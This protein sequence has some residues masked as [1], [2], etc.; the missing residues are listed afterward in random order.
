MKNRVKVT[1]A[2]LTIGVLAMCGNMTGYATESADAVSTQANE[3]G[4]TDAGGSKSYAYVVTYDLNEGI[5]GKYEGTYVGKYK[6]E[7]PTVE[8]S[9]ITPERAG[10]RLTG[11]WYTDTNNIE[12]EISTTEKIDLD[13]W[14]KDTREATLTAEW[15]QVVTVTVDGTETGTKVAADERISVNTAPS[16]TLKL[17]KWVVN[18]SE[19]DEN[20]DLI[21]NEKNEVTIEVKA[22]P[23]VNHVINVSEKTGFGITKDNAN[24]NFVSYWSLQEGYLVQIENKTGHP[25]KLTDTVTVPNDDK[26][27]LEMGNKLPEKTTDGYFTI[28]NPEI[29]TKNQD[30]ITWNKQNVKCTNLTIGKADVVRNMKISFAT[31]EGVTYTGSAD[32]I[33]LENAQTLS[34]KD[35][36]GET[37]AERTRFEQYRWTYKVKPYDRDWVDS[38]Q[39]TNWEN[40]DPDDNLK[41]T[42]TYDFPYYEFQFIPVWQ[43]KVSFETGFPKTETTNLPTTRDVIYQDEKSTFTKFPELTDS[44]KRYVFLGWKL[45][46]DTSDIIYKNGSDNQYTLSNPSVTF[47]GQ[48][49][50][51]SYP[52]YWTF[53]NNEGRPTESSILYG[54]KIIFPENPTRT[55]YTFLGWKMSVGDASTDNGVKTSEKLYKAGDEVMMP[56]GAVTMTAQWQINT[57][58][59]TYNGNGGTIG[60]YTGRDDVTY[61]A[62]YE[63]KNVSGI[64]PTRY[65]YKFLGWKI[66][67][68]GDTLQAGSSFTMPAKNVELVAQWEGKS[69][70]LGNKG[71][72]DLSN[73]VCYTYNGAFRIKGDPSNYQDKITFYV[74]KAGEYTFE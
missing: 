30:Y 1:I 64:T 46:D 36:L 8:L 21:P 27:I 44:G 56:A 11:W 28:K 60:I 19:N 17:D 16:K 15:T 23:A 18:K 24:A 29:S 67:G 26:Q 13:K 12:K 51:I 5:Y 20:R 43:S 52:I 25:L 53:E 63:I 32:L 71:K 47:V 42:F 4:S 48:W 31:Q 37:K 41:N 55:G 38:D 61:N 62:S 33:S 58:T 2:A 50:A 65:G 6:I 57:Y 34:V 45:K 39:A 66:N 9:K 22:A 14:L 35:L 3:D 68:S 72:H 49:K 59:V 40:T 54:Q 73:G 74:P 7:T 10:Y 69:P 70:N